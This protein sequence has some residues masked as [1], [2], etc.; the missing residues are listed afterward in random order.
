MPDGIVS[1]WMNAAELEWLRD[2]AK[3][4]MVVVEVGC[5]MGITTRE[6]ARVTPGKVYAVDTW[7]GSEEHKK[8]LNG[9]DSDWL[10]RCFQGNV[11]GFQNVTPIRRHSVNAADEFKAMGICPDMVF[12]DASH[13]YENV[14]ADILAWREVLATGGLLCGHDFDAGREGVVNAVRELIPNPKMGAGSIWYAA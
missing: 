7:Q 14:K 10:F 11:N 3:T 8:L 12:I 1:G 6:L 4:R 9:K 5:W 13:D 2:K